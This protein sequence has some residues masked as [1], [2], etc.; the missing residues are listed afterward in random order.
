MRTG[1]RCSVLPRDSTARQ[2]VEAALRNSPVRYH[3][4]LQTA[5]DGIIT[6]DEC[7]I[8]E[9][10]NPAAERLFGY[11]A[12]EMIGQNVGCSCPRRSGRPTI[13]SLPI[14]SPKRSRMPGTQPV[15]LLLV[16]AD[17]GHAAWRWW[18]RLRSCPASLADRSSWELP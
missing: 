13:L 8:I 15:T 5:V 11:P 2:Q 17:P 3:A 16:E 1:R 14:R 6:T 7:G 12:D 4:I 10:V 9:S 18:L